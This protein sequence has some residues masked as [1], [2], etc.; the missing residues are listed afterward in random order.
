[1]KP[2]DHYLQR[3]R[4][5]KALPWIQPGAHVLDVGCSD[6]ALFGEGRL[7]SGV[8]VDLLD[9]PIRLSPP[10]ERRTGEFPSI[11]GPDERFDAI[12]MLAVVEH[13]DDDTLREWAASVPGMLTPGGRLI[14]TTPSPLVDHILHVGIALHLLDGMELHQ[15]HGFDPATVPTFFGTTGLRLLCHRRFQLGLNHLFVFESVRR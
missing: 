14:L 13:L 15:H 1:M 10:F 8:G 12:C 2:V 9:S 7:A 4:I 3:Q 5:A 11:I 6:G